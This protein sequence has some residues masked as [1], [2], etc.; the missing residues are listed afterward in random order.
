MAATLTEA[1]AAYQRWRL[2]LLWLHAAAAAAAGAAAGTTAGAPSPSPAR[3]AAAAG[4]SAAAGSAGAAGAAGAA[5]VATSAIGAAGAVP[6]HFSLP[7]LYVAASGP[8]FWGQPSA[9]AEV[10]TA[11]DLL[12]EVCGAGEQP[13]VSALQNCAAL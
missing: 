4:P 7:A 3:S 5:A 6:E 12:R 11:E 13:S 1:A 10:P 2:G 8:G 9:R